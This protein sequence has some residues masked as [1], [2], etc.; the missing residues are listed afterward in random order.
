MILVIALLL[1]DPAALSAEAAKLAQAQRLEEA[2]NLWE[3]ALAADPKFF[4]ALFNLGFFHFNAKRFE[5]AIPLLERAAGVRPADFNT[6]YVLGA[7]L[8][9]AGRVDDALRHWRQ[10]HHGILQALPGRRLP[11]LYPARQVR[12]TRACTRRN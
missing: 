2:K 3:K 10:V 6:R 12:R 11:A 4:P 5:K 7:A 9:Q 1:A 8:S